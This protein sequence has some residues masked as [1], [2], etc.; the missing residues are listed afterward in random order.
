MRHL[1]V[2]TVPFVVSAFVTAAFWPSVG[3]AQ[4]NLNDQQRTGRMIFAQSCGVCHLTTTPN[5]RT[6]GPSLSRE[7]AGGNAD[8]IRTIISE[9]GLRM[10]AFKHDLERPQIDSII[11]YLT[12]VQPATTASNPR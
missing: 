11:A 4:D 9:G 10:P 7:T 1:S 3:S 8:V 5:A 12:T 2:L 6:Y